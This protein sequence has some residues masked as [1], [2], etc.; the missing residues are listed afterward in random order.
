[1]WL[2]II[3]PILQHAKRVEA[4]ATLATS[5]LD[6]VATLQARSPEL[7]RVT[8]ELVE[9]RAAPGAPVQSCVGADLALFCPELD[10]LDGFLLGKEKLGKVIAPIVRRTLVH[11]VLARCVDM[12]FTLCFTLSF[13][14]S[15]LSV[16]VFLSL[17]CFILSR[18][19]TLFLSRLLSVVVS[20]FLALALC[21]SPI[22]E[23]THTAPNTSHTSELPVEDIAPARVTFGPTGTRKVHRTECV[24]TLLSDVKT[25]LALG[26]R[27]RAVLLWVRSKS[28]P[29]AGAGGGRRR[30]V[31]EVEGDMHE[32]IT[33]VT[34]RM[35]TAATQA[36]SLVVAT[37]SQ[38]LVT[39]YAISYT[40][41]GRDDR[42]PASTEWRGR[43]RHG[44][45]GESDTEPTEGRDRE[46][47]AVW[48]LSQRDSD[49]ERMRY[50]ERERDSETGKRACS[51]REV[52]G[53]L[54]DINHCK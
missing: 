54:I 17:T 42:G 44:R 15:A 43:A 20:L 35:E 28:A 33:T 16:S 31:P 13:C 2:L 11:M 25:C 10:A 41:R 7:A 34:A 32:R 40:V 14:L 48:L 12:C 26:V 8:A 22:I 45:T 19:F 9:H 51:A 5:L 23:I 52:A 29:A 27:F 4:C 50:S 46:T 53:V 49:R 6:E 1:M 39:R 47:A 30:A 36:V 37:A 38:F 21:R 18:C 24:S 3:S